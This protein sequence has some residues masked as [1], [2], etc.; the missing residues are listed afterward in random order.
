MTPSRDS[1]SVRLGDLMRLDREPV[2]VD[3]AAEYPNLGIYSFGKG[4]FPKPPISGAA[5][6]A[7][8]LYR[9]CAGQFIYSRLFAFEGAFALVPS[10]MDG[11]YVSNEYP[12]FDVDESEAL[13]EFLRIAICRR[14]TWQELA[15]M[16][17]GAGHRR[18]RLQP[19]ALLAFQLDL[20]PLDE[21]RAIVG[22]VGAAEEAAQALVVEARA[23]KH[24]ASAL[25]ADL[26]DGPGWRRVKFGDVAALDLDQVAV[27]P[28]AEYA[29]AGLLIA[30]GGLFARPTI[31][32]SETTYARLHRLRVNQLV[33]RKLTA[34]EGPI[35]I[36]PEEFDGAFVS[37]EFPT[38]TLDESLLLPE[39]M[40]FVCQQSWFHAEMRARSTGTAERRNRLKPADLLE[41]ELDLPPLVEQR[42]IAAA[43]NAALA[44]EREAESAR[45]VAA[46]LPDELLSPKEERV[47]A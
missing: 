32:G 30:G 37:P 8:T 45:A 29:V 28:E 4:V 35:T 36:V 34:W 40:R 31:R 27:V 23:A 16:T 12:T 25:H 38:F 10:E 46:A 5:T 2:K 39:F 17:V 7:P 43:T 33:Y 21:Q 42:A 20:P 11:W 44:A 24:L 15:G 13:A 47:A 41:I 18:Q 14:R 1:R 9:V 22:A 6:S 3:P 26:S 19:D